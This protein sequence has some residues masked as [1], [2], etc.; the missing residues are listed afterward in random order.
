[1]KYP[2]LLLIISLLYCGNS[3]AQILQSE[4]PELQKVDVQE[5]LGRTIPLGLTFTDTE[6][7]TVRLG[8]H[9]HANEPVLLCM[10]YSNCPMLCHVVLEAVAKGVKQLPWTP[11]K[12]YNI[13]SVSFDPRDTLE[14]VAGVKERTVAL[15]GS[16]AETAAKANWHFLF[17]AEK[18]SRRL[19]DSLGFMYYY[20]EENGQWAHPAVLF[21]LTPDGAI[22]RYLY[23]VNYKEK[24]LR[25]ALMEASQGKLGNTI[26]RIM[27]YCF[28]Y[29]P[30][31]K[32][33]VAMA[34][35]IMK[36]GGAA[37]FIILSLILG[38]F[39]LREYSRRT[40]ARSGVKQV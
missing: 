2:I 39:W 34:A 5:H 15:L 9:F 30:D 24:D 16:E 26:D 35:N 19:A 29:D 6:G 40:A 23:G 38:I 12:E 32:G 33:Y 11:G 8:D 36:L 21:V 3:S 31:A 7:R 18:D 37:T 20:Q 1:M 13:I 28:H 22:S 17:G 10:F 14:L 25:L 27:L 4:V